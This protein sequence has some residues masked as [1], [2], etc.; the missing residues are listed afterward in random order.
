MHHH[1]PKS[2]SHSLKLGRVHASLKEEEEEAAMDLTLLGRCNHSIYDMG[3]Y[4]FWGTALAGG[5]A[6]VADGYS[7]FDHPLLNAIREHPP[8]RWTLLNVTSLN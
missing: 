8:D 3:S 5:D 1:H 7:K 2:E 4:G 6:I